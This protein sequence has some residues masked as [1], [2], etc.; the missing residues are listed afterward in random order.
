M[1]E[2][3]I[4]SIIIPFYNSKAHLKNCLES[5][6]NQ[7]FSESFEIILIDDASNDNGR[8]IIKIYKSLNTQL[9]VLNE[10]SGPSASR[11]LGILKSRGKYIYFLDADDTIEPSTLTILFNTLNEE[12]YDL[13]FSDKKWIENSKNQRNNIYDYSYDRSFNNSELNKIMWTR[14]NDPMSAGKIFGLTGR[15]MKRSIIIKN[16]ILFEEKLRYLEDDTFVWDFLANISKAR[17]VRRQLY[18]YH[19]YPQL[20]TASSEGV[21]RSF[22]ISNF[23]IVK[24]HIENS[25]KKRNFLDK[26]AKKISNQGF[27]FLLIGGLI[28]YCRSIF[29]EKINQADGINHFRLIIKSVLSD[30]EVSNLIRGYKRSKGESFLIPLAIILKS[31]KLLEFACMKRAKEITKIRRNNIA[32]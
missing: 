20:N 13:V 4:L 15:L 26:D 27:I 19:I 25:L 18:N 2:E 10:N 29:L 17:Y 12:N 14:F 21:K 11:N 31:S 28:S 24:K 16:K 5:L 9:Y 1:S 32:K 8:E 22:S 3:L 23:K 30:K 7:N 6:Q